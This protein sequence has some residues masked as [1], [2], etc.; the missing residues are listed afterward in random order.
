MTIGNGSF[1]W[2]ESLESVSIPNT[3]TKIEGFAFLGCFPLKN[4]TIPDSVTA[5]EWYAFSLTAISSI[6]IPAG[7]KRI[8]DCA[9][10]GTCLESVTIPD[11]VTEIGNG[12]FEFCLSLKS[13]TIPK[14]VTNIE[15]DAFSKCYYLTDVTYKGTKDDWDKITK[16]KGNDWLLTST[17]NMADGTT[18]PGKMI[19]NPFKVSGKTAKVKY[20]KLKKKSQKLT[21][22]KVLNIRDSQ[23]VLSYKITSV[24]RGK[25]KKFKKYF[26]IDSKKSTITVKK[27]LKKGTYKITCKV[28]APQLG[29]MKSATRTVTFKI[30][31]K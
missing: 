30:K 9:F 12:A 20:K 14:S 19:D 13:I 29:R 24:K 15:E 2:C 10:S 8:E 23:T 11:G 28:T 21:V 1:S 31:V 17:I 16:D 3:V 22:N 4:V 25:S 18:I 26:K 27:K 7:I 6:K 5:I